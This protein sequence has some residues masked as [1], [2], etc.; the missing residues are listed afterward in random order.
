MAISGIM[1]AGSVQL[2]VKEMRPAVQHYTEV[3][4]LI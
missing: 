1:R 3:L 2:R 4:G